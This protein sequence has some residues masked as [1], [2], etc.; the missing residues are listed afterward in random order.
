MKYARSPSMSTPRCIDLNRL[1]AQVA[2][3]EQYEFPCAAQ[4]ASAGLCHEDL[5]RA[6]DG[7]DPAAHT[8]VAGCVV[9]PVTGEEGAIRLAPTPFLRR[10]VTCLGAGADV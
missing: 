3:T 8:L 9:V 10:R 1:I 2:E 5:W 4:D 6:G 7:V